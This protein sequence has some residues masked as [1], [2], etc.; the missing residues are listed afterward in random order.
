MNL[1]KKVIKYSFV[2][3]LILLVSRVPDRLFLKVNGAEK[4]KNPNGR[5][6]TWGFVGAGGGGELCAERVWLV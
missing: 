2:F 3:G 1:F 6:D 4:F 5:N